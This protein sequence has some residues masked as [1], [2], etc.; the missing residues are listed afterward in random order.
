MDARLELDGSRGEGGGQILRSALALSVVL[1]R[2]FELAKIRAGRPK[3]GLRR[4]HLA[5]VRAAAMLCGAQVRGDELG[6]QR[7]TFEPSE[8]LAQSVDIDIGSAGSAALVVQTLLPPALMASAPVRATIRGGTH[9]PMAPSLDFLSEAFAPALASM[10]AA[11]ELTCV[12][13]GFAPSGGGE[14]AL[15]VTPRALRPLE[16]LEAGEVTRRSAI[17]VLARLPTHVADRELAV[18]RAELGFTEAECARR[19]VDAD[20]PGNALILLVE[21]AGGGREVVTGLGERG[22]R[23]ELV[24]RRACAELRT[25]LDAAVP[26]GEH[27]TDQLLLPMALG[28]GGRFRCGPL[29]SHALTNIETIAAFLPERRPRV[30]QD[31]ASWIVEVPGA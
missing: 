2:P 12:R 5:C 28:G 21:R 14:V 19:E 27:L 13:H 3:P 24:A 25:W 10:G 8:E 11:V 29:S 26:V 20:G 9:N 22:T 18:V 7:L 23:A 17:A 15:A 6:S 16:L 4:Q 1:R 31:G 30:T